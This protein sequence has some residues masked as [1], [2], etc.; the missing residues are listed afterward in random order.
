MQCFSTDAEIRSARLQM[1]DEFAIREATSADAHAIHAMLLKLAKATNLPDGISS[2][3]EDIAR[4]GFGRNPAF[5]ALIATMSESPVGLALYFPEFSSWKGRRGIYLQDLYVSPQQRGAGVGSL[6]IQALAA[7]AAECGATYLR[8]AVDSNNHG[9][10]VFYEKLGFVC[11]DERLLHLA[12]EA[13]DAVLSA[14]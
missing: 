7:R 12:G 13:F 11:K 4:E 14:Q 9:A 10:A 3:P 5:H 6:L 2:T 1:T 8:L